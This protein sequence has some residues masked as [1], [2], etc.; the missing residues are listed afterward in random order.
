M[1]NPSNYC[2]IQ[3]CCW[4]Y[5]LPHRLEISSW[6]SW[7]FLFHTTCFYSVEFNLELIVRITWR[8]WKICF[9]PRVSIHCRIMSLCITQH[10][11]FAKWA[12]EFS[13]R[14]LPTPDF[15]VHQKI[16]RGNLI[17]LLPAGECCFNFVPHF[18]I[19][20]LFL[21]CHKNKLLLFNLIC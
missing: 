6:R 1:R 19:Q 5:W 18:L 10:M 21:F 12:N 14:T 16:T 4:Y 11:L 3:N 13:S 7:K 9:V 8:S 17:L 15:I 20:C 2:Y